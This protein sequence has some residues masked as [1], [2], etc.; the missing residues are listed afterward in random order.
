MALAAPP[1]TVSDVKDQLVGLD[2][3]L[4]AAAI[5]DSLYDDTKIASRIPAM[6]RKFEKETQF[7]INAVQI[8]STDNDGVYA[9]ANAVSGISMDNTGNLRVILEAAYPYYPSEAREY[10]H[11]TLRERPVQVVQ[12]MR[13]NLSNTYTVYTMPVEWYR[14]EPRSGKFHIQPTTGSLLAGGNLT[15]V[16]LLQQLFGQVPALPQSLAYDYIAG[17][18][19]GWQQSEEYSEIFLVLCEYCALQVLKEISNT[20]GAGIASKNV[21]DGTGLSQ[22][23]S[24]DRFQQRKAEL[25]ANVLA[26]QQLIKEQDTPFLLGAL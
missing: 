23:I 7:R 10:F 12:R 3:W 21:S 17:L 26:F 5:S 1:I 6:I 14:L 13:V 4:A 8:V 20:F 9:P 24:Y 18:P 25:Q 19:T 15:A 16:A 11:V 22:G 2:A